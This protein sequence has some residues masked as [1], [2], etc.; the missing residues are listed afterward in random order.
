MTQPDVQEVADEP[1][2]SD[3]E[4][5]PLLALEQETR[6]LDRQQAETAAIAQVT[7]QRRFLG[8][9]FAWLVAAWMFIVMAVVIADGAAGDAFE[10]DLPVL[11]ALVSSSGGLVSALIFGAARL[12]FRRNDQA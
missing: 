3:S 6:Y 9:F 2:S 5:G 10:V 7:E 1:P 8:S 11:L 4:A 12:I